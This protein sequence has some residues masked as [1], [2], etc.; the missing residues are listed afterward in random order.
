MLRGAVSWGHSRCSTDY[1]TVF[2]RVSSFID[3]I[4]AKMSGG[5]GGGG[6]GGGKCILNALSYFLFFDTNFN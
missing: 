3:W 4:N 1:Y 6:G 2:A 5:G